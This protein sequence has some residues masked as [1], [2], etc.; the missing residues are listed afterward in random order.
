ML[1]TSS[2]SS[3]QHWNSLHSLILNHT[4][5][6]HTCT[7]PTPPPT[8]QCWWVLL[9]ALTNQGAA[10]HNTPDNNAG[11]VAF[12]SA[13]AT[14]GGVACTAACSIIR[15][16][17]TTWPLRRSLQ[18]C[19]VWNGRNL[20]F[21]GLIRQACPVCCAEHGN[22]LG[23]SLGQ[24]CEHLSSAR[25]NLLRTMHQGASTHT[26]HA[27]WGSKENVHTGQACLGCCHTMLQG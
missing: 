13:A 25:G 16:S 12:T 1:C 27:C 23:D 26:T 8:R 5:S 2:K 20:R 21:Q 4:G 11:G 10:S 14:A 24:L 15:R 6:A 7:S 9:L 17:C 22:T 18:T 19:A 3:W